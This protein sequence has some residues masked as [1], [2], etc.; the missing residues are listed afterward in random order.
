MVMVN[1]VRCRMVF[2]PFLCASSHLW[3]HCC[4]QMLHRTY[5]AI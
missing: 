5:G 2:V 3:L 1:W 4:W